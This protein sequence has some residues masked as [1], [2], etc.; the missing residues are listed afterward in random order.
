MSHPNGPRTGRP[1]TYAS[2]GVVSTPH[3]LA[4][5]AGLE[6]L[7][8]GGN[9]I[10]AAIAASAALCVVY[11]HMTGLG[12]DGF[13]LIAGPDTGGVQA[14]N[15][16]GPAAQ[17]ATIERY[18]AHG[19][20]IPARGPLAA[21]TVPGSVDGWRAAH[22][23]FGRLPWADLF[24]AA[25]HYARE[26]MP[27]SRSLADW[28][29]ADLPILRE[30]PETARIFLPEGE[31]QRE[32]GRLVQADLARSLEELASSGA[33][34]FYEGDIARRICAGLE[35]EGSPLRPEDFAAYRAAWVQPPRPTAAMRSW[36]CRP[37]HRA[38]RRSRS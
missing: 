17:A 38:S 20:E 16:S 6:A 15:A 1:P 8:R 22:E 9:A 12:G 31:P 26:G 4:S 23:R 13:W 25:I 11:P 2:R 29:V 7:Q 24:S 10:D 28:L 34:A 32:G 21:L 3:S 27:V 5:A 37:T 33:R 35:P 36:R 19:S 18:R 30:F 14:L